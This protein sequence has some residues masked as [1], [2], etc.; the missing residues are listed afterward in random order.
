MGR[1]RATVTGTLGNK[2]AK[3]VGQE[4]STVQ[5]KGSEEP[6]RSAQQEAIPSLHFRDIS[7]DDFWS[8]YISQRKPVLIRGQGDWGTEHW[9]TDYLESIAV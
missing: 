5:A 2:R 4:S 1:K 3:T 9:Q 7:P 6:L 8:E